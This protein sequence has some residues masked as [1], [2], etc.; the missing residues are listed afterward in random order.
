MQNEDLISVIMPAY[1][2]GKYIRESIE[3]VLHQTYQN[4]ELIIVDDGSTDNTRDVIECFVKDT[5]R[6]RCIEQQNGKQGKARN[7]GIKNA[8]GKLIAFLDADD[9]WYPNKLERQ[10][11]LLKKMNVDV[12]FSCADQ[13][14]SKGEKTG[15]WEPSET[16]ELFFGDD[17]LA[18]FFRRNIVN[19]FTVLAKRDA[20]EK[21]GRFNEEPEIQNIEDYDLWLRMLQNECKFM[22]M[23]EILGAYRLHE[24]QTLKGKPVVLK[25][26]KMLGAIKVKK[27]KMMKEKRK[28]MRLWLICGLRYDITKAE[29]W[30]MI[31][32]Y[33]NFIGRKFFR[34]LFFITPQKVLNKIITY[35]CKE[36][37]FQSSV[38]YIRQKTVR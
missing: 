16:C 2:A 18:Y 29:L 24:T 26:L 10:L 7:A 32:F 14:N 20:I 25:I 5:K 28:A 15:C 8:N 11:S 38:A 31:S 9:L 13:I 34:T 37:F 1:N 17:G 6:I 4:W 21:A 30:N 23:N 22:L 19:I 33:P 12:I 35:S 36:S 27:K 3:S